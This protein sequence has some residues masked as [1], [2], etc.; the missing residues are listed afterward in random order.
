[1]FEGL[2][3]PSAIGKSITRVNGADDPPEKLRGSI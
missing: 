2:M 3:S 1:M